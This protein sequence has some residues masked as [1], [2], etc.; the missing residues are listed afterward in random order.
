MIPSILPP[1]TPWK[2]FV[3]GAGVFD[4]KVVNFL[5]AV[6]CGRLIRDSITALLTIQYGPEIVA[7]ATNL[8]TR[9]SRAILVLFLLLSG[10]L[11]FWVVRKYRGR[12]A[13]G[14]RAAE[15]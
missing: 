5:L 2:L 4:M 14:A 3:F 1:P 9:H 10:F 11:V 15:G 8:A 7:L 6:F 13:R 12:G